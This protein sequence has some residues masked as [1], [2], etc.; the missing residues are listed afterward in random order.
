[1]KTTKRRCIEY[2]MDNNR[3]EPLVSI[4]IPVYN[5]SNYLRQALDCALR[6]TYKNYEIIVVNDGSDDNN[7]TEKIALSYGDSIR[8]FKK[9]NGGVSS[10]L[11]VGIKNMQGEY[12]SWLSHDDLYSPDKLTKQVEQ[13]EKLNEKNAIVLC[14]LNCIDA[15]GSHILFTQKHRRLPEST[16]FNG[17]VALEDLLKRETFYGCT[18]LIPKRTLEECGYFDETLRYSQ[19]YYICLQMCLNNNH[20][21]YISDELVSSRIHS[22]QLS[23]LGRQLCH[24]EAIEIGRRVIKPL[25]HISN[26]K[27]NFLYFYAIDVAKYGNMQVAYQCI[28]E[29]ETV[30]LFSLLDRIIVNF[31]ILYGKIRPQIRK[32][33]YALFRGFKTK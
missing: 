30:Q 27:K 4:I 24:K 10:A 17:K 21:I 16:V 31:Y 26:S 33:Y 1:M 22:A 20:F 3:Y 28:Q 18:M 8:Y 5:G 7:E 32:L 9:S 25:A 19:D 15:E 2:S 23:Q 6:Q 29:A 12:F 13:L 11:N 14:E